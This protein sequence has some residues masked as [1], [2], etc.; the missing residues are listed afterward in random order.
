MSLLEKMRAYERVHKIY[1]SLSDEDG[2]P[3][4]FVADLSDLIGDADKL[5]YE[6]QKCRRGVYTNAETY[7]ELASWLDNF[8]ELV[9]ECAETVR[10]YAAEEG[11][12]SECMQSLDESLFEDEVVEAEIPEEA[13]IIVEPVVEEPVA[14]PTPEENSLQSMLQ[15]LI[16]DEWDAIEAYNGTVQTISEMGAQ[17]ELVKVL[18][19]I[20]AEE[21][22]HVGQLQKALEF[23]SPQTAKIKEGEVE[24]TE[25]MTEPVTSE[26]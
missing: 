10:G 15:F 5:T 6:L 3:E 24:A 9:S 14:V 8:A 16:K 2:W 13:P 21:L 1:E 17:D 23:V 7:T 22:V 26:V 11:E 12:M 20:S 19:D 18:Q 25:Q 4:E